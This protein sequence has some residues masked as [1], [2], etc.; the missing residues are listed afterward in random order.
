MSICSDENE[1]IQNMRCLIWIIE[2]RG[3]EMNENSFFPYSPNVLN[4]NIV[5]VV[6]NCFEN[7]I[8]SHFVSFFCS[9]SISR[10]LTLSSADRMRL[11]L[12]FF[13]ATKIYLF[14]FSSKIT[15][16]KNPIQLSLIVVE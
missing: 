1:Q 4:I 2:W 14:I 10:S 8:H 12:F 13:F 11:F 9:R 15:T 16:L 7:E 5:A 6:S 3:T